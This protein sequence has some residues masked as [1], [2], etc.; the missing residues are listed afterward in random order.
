VHYLDSTER[1]VPSWGPWVA[2]AVGGPGERV[3]KLARAARLGVE[4]GPRLAP[5]PTIP[6]RE[7]FYADTRPARRGNAPLR[8]TGSTVG[9]VPS[10]KPSTA[11]PRRRCLVAAPLQPACQRG[12]RARPPHSRRRDCRRPRARDRRNQRDWDDTA[13]RLARDLGWT[14]ACAS[15]RA[16][17][18]CQLRPTIQSIGYDGY[19]S[20]GSRQTCTGNCPAHIHVS[21]VSGCYGSSEL[22]APCG[23]L[24]TFRVS[25]EQGDALNA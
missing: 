1:D 15:S 18:A 21:W 16:R 2:P 14:T 11:D 13:G 4:C 22:V 24:M 23:R 20:H 25:A 6:A 10:S 5:R 9:P 3:P 19:P 12:S 17:P 8:Q 7:R